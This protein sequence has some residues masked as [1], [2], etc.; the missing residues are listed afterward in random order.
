MAAARALPLEAAASARALPFELGWRNIVTSLRTALAAV[1]ALGLAYALSMGAP[2]WAAV[3]VYVLAQGTVGQSLAKAAWRAAG[4]IFGGLTGLALVALFSQA[5][6]LLAAI[7]ATAL[8]LCFYVGARATNYASYAGILAGYTILIVAF[9][10][11]SAPRL[12]WAIASDRMG[13]ILIGIA[14]ASVAN[15]TILPR[16][17]GE[18]LGKALEQTLCDL[19]LYASTALRL[20]AGPAVFAGLRARMAGQV[21]AFDGL[22]AAT[23]FEDSEIRPQRQRLKRLVHEF[24][25][26]LA[27]TRGLYRRLEAFADQ[28]AAPVGALIADALD[29]TAGWIERT[30]EDPRLTSAP[31]K[32]H[33]GFLEQRRAIGEATARVAALAQDCPFATR[34][35]AVLI[36]RRVGI[37]LDRLAIAAVAQAAVRRGLDGGAPPR[38]TAQADMGE[39]REAV[40]VSLRAALTV[41]LIAAIWM[42]TGWSEGAGAATSG[43]IILR[44]TVDRDDPRPAARIYIGAIIAALSAAYLAMI[45]VLPRLE[46]YLG[47]A[48]FLTLLLLPAGLMM[49]SPRVAPSGMFFAIFVL[50]QLAT[51]NGFAPDELAFVN[52]AA[53]LLI[54]AAIGLAMLL[55]FPVT[56]QPQR[57]R[58]WRR[59]IGEILPAVARGA[60]PP[61]PAADEIVALLV[62]LLP[63]LA[64][65]RQADDEFL[66]GGL[67]AASAAHELGRLAR[68]GALPPGDEAAAIGLFLRRLAS[69]LEKIARG[70]AEERPVW[71]AEAGKAVDAARAQLAQAPRQTAELTQSLLQADAALCFISDCFDVD[72]AFFLQGASEN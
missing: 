34:A 31:E 3:T 47:Y 37:L 11:A 10:G 42:A 48:V 17:A 64:L 52:S 39:R 70:R 1:A 30:A 57:G 22:S 63:R 50:M 33:A 36:L 20:S 24:L 23:L 28:R 2:H 51:G 14:C 13:E 62:G 26:A 27:V 40:L 21:A 67:G 45:F 38:A 8:G 53:G 69:I 32:L 61:R 59:I 18:K 35:R 43:A 29:Q 5:P 60:A 72:R 9:D 44:I 25:V 54:G 55:L 56:S 65:E 16:Y 58:S 68:V 71:L 66:R 49:Q 6:E 19:M 12:A 4:T 15:A 41:A 7:T 46:D